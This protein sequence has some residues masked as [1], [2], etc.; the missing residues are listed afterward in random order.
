[1]QA[2]VLVVSVDVELAWGVNHRLL[3]GDPLA[4]SLLKVMKAR[5][6]SNLRALLRISE[7]LRMPFTWGIVGHLFL[8]NCSRSGGLPHGDMPRPEL[9][10]HRDWYSLDPCS[11]A[12]KDPLWYAPDVVQTLLES[13]V[14]QEIACHSFSH[15]DFFQCSEEVARAEVRKCVEA[16]EDYGIRPVTFIFPRNHVAHLDVLREEG[17]RVFRFKARR[18]LRPPRKFLERL[19]D[20]AAPLTAR[21]VKI[22]GLIGVPGTLLFQ[23]SRPRDAWRLEV[24]AMRG[25]RRAAK[26]GKVFHITMHDYVEND[27]T[28]I[29][30]YRVLS[31]AA[32]LREKGVLEIATI[33]QCAELYS[34]SCKSP[35]G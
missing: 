5:S 12:E 35:P 6:R 16:A 24:T 14:E 26:S 18:K 3:I 2:G 10:R 11:S 9:F 21:P 33:A 27:E 23:T 7:T 4:W 20:L 28:L 8:G 15:V 25:I 31:Y 19:M 17:F 13:R 34:P 29:A 1:M 32:R 30:L 22:K